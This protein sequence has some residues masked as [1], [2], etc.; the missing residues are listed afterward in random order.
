LI[1]GR[2]IPRAKQAATLGSMLAGVGYLRRTRVLLAA[3]TLDLFAV[4]LGGAVTLLPVYARDIL[5]VGPSGLGWLRAAPS[6]G[7]VA[8]ALLI[9]F[10]PVLR[11]AGPTLLWAVAGFG[12]VTLV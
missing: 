6:I 5:A 3:I 11:R 10:L 2:P 4:L 1:R 12:L 8:M 7:A 9:A